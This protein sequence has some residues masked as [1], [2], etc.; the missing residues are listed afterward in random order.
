MDV[1]QLNDRWGAFDEE[2][3][4][5]VFEIGTYLGV[6]YVDV[7]NDDCMVLG[8]C[9]DMRVL[10]FDVPTDMLDWSEDVDV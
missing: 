9:N 1:V 2:Y 8:V 5:V 3:E 4:Y 6:T 10:E 7:D